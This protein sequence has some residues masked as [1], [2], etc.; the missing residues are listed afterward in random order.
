MGLGKALSFLD[1]LK[2][3]SDV[4]GSR[5]FI[6]K[7]IRYHCHIGFVIIMKQFQTLNF[8]ISVLLLKILCFF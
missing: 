6:E 4:Q 3:S 5:S 8:S 1:E 2:A 7:P